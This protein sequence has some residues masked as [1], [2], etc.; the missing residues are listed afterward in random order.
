VFNSFTTNGSVDLQL[1]QQAN[2]CAAIGLKHWKVVHLT[3]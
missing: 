2:A 3:Q 1:Q